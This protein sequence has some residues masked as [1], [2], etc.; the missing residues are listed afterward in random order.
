MHPDD[1]ADSPLVALARI[2][3]ASASP[4]SCPVSPST[5]RYA[6]D[7][8]ESSTAPTPAPSPALS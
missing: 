4:L 3:A 1:L 7:S 2:L 8:S 6:G 5:D